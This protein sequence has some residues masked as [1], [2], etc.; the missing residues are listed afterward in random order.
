MKTPAIIGL[1]A[2][3]LMVGGYFYLKNKNTP[4]DK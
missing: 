2:L 1:V 4:A 3:V